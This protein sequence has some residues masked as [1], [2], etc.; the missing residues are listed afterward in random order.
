MEPEETDTALT[1]AAKGTVTEPA[2]AGSRRTTLRNF[3]LAGV[4]VLLIGLYVAA[5]RYQPLSIRPSWA[6][7]HTPH[8]SEVK[9]SLE[10]KL[11][12]T[13]PLGVSV[14]AM[15]PK[16]YADPPVAVHSLMPC[17]HIKGYTMECAQASNGLMIGNKFQPFAL[18][19]EG[20]MPVAWQ[21][22]FSCRPQATG[23]FISGPVEVRVTYRFAWFT[24]SVLLVLANTETSGGNACSSTG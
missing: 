23:S 24:H 12:N 3:L 17:I 4:A 7:W 2:Q 9:M 22:S 5:S 6:S 14:L 16:V 11:S 18:S 19:G 1:A 20:S 15:H 10:T 8:S 13:G 21:Y